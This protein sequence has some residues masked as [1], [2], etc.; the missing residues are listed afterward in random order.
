MDSLYHTDFYRWTQQQ[1]DFL[2]HRPDAVEKE[3]LAH[4]LRQ[5]AQAYEHRL[6]KLLAVLLTDLLV[7]QY[8]YDFRSYPQKCRIELQRDRIRDFLKQHPSLASAVPELFSAAYEE[9][10][11]EAA[12]RTD[13]PDTDFHTGQWT[14]DDVLSDTILA[15]T[16]AGTRPTGRTGRSQETTLV[17]SGNTSCY[18]RNGNTGLPAPCLEKGALIWPTSTTPTF[19]AGC[20]SKPLC[21]N[22][23]GLTNLT[24]A[25]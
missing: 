12:V 9:A 2:K 8:E 16:M 23:G 24:L 19:T 7:W 15:G 4:E 14:V 11:Y 3:T 22:R 10:V 20:T 1:V 18:R 5:L 25:T 13:Y 6:Q 21:W 17:C